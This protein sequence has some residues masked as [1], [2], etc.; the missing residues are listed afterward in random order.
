MRQLPFRRVARFEQL[1]NAYLKRRERETEIPEYL[2]NFASLIVANLCCLI[3]FGEPKIDEPLPK[4]WERC[5]E[6]AAWQACREKHGGFSE[7]GR[8]DGTPFD[9]LGVPHIA[10]YFHRYFLP[11]LPGADDIEK[12]SMIFKEAPPWLLWFTCGDMDAHILGIELPD[13]SEISR[14]ARG[15]R[16]FT[17]LPPG[18]FELQRLPDG[19]YDRYYTPQ[20]RD[21]FEDKAK[22]M[23]PRE[24]KRMRRY[25]DGSR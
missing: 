17:P 14:F 23:T 1:A 18:P 21:A 7:Y 9:N 25:Y 2:R 22:N 11:D 20:T 4:A 5:L 24:R 12:F 8:D 13:L 6:S 3:L 10:K 16:L 19:V 15:G